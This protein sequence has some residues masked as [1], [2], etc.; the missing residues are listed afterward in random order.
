MHLEELTAPSEKQ[1]VHQQR[2]P[3]ASEINKTRAFALNSQ[4]RAF[5]LNSQTRAFALNSLP[6][7]AW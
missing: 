5:A 1:L 2:L 6:I 7:Y 4:T 3:V